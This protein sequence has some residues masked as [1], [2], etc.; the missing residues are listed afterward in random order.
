MKVCT[1]QRGKKRGNERPRGR[2]AFSP[3]L[4][5]SGCRENKGMD[6]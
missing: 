2:K 6:S 5:P 3:K 4:A 1:K